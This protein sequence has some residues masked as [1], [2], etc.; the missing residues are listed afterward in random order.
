M[1]NITRYQASTATK[2]VDSLLSPQMNN[3]WGGEDN[4]GLGTREDG[5][6]SLSGA[7]NSTN[8]L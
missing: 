2:E 8:F 6:F 1:T 5:T 3:F 7:F 4:P